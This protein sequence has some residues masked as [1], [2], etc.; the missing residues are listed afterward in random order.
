MSK[1]IQYALFALMVAFFVSQMWAE[2]KDGRNSPSW[3]STSGELV[4][5]RIKEIVNE[6]DSVWRSSFELL[7]DYTYEVDGQAYHGHRIRAG[8][9]SYMLESQALEDL[10]RFQDMAELTVFYDPSKPKS[11][12]L[13]HR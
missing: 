6:R 8:G 10:H 1:L 11:S 2:Y 4:D 7:V 13:E 3:P 9:K 5:A 12:V